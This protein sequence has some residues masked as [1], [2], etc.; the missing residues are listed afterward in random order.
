MTVIGSTALECEM[1]PQ[2]LIYVE[3]DICRDLPD[4]LA[5]ALDSHAPDL[6]G[7]SFRILL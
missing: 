4:Q 6:L 1:K 2:C 7:L 3:H 5:D